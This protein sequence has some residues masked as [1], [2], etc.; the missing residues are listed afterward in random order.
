ML[1]YLPDEMLDVEQR[2]LKWEGIAETVQKTNE[3]M[4]RQLFGREDRR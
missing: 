2:K 3:K 4:T 1:R